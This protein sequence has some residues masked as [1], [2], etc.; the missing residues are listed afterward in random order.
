[1]YSKA[2]SNRHYHNVKQDIDTIDKT[3][4][5][6]LLALD[7]IEGRNILEKLLLEIKKAIL[8]LII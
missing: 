3:L 4:E 1:M 5:R 7:F 2:Y 8:R 6:C